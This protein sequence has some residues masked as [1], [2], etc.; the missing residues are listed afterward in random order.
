MFRNIK[1]N[2][3]ISI[4]IM[5]AIIIVTLLVPFIN[6]LNSTNKIN[7]SSLIKEQNIEWGEDELPGDFFGDWSYPEFWEDTLTHEIIYEKPTQPGGYHHYE[8]YT[9]IGLQATRNYTSK[10]NNAI[11]DG[12][13]GL[14]TDEHYGSSVKDNLDGWWCLNPNWILNDVLYY[15]EDWLVWNWNENLHKG[16]GV[17]VDNVD[18]KLSVSIGDIG[19]VHPGDLTGNIYIYIWI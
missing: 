9:G 10:F 1:T 6:I 7:N 17:D 12:Y 16:E 5:W 8:A 13:I 15:M 4:L 18:V 2:K 3:I 19:L 14:Y 11:N